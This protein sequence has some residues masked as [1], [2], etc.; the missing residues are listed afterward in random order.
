MGNI[1]A[2]GYYAEY[3][4]QQSNALC[5]KLAVHEATTRV[6]EDCSKDTLNNIREEL[7]S[8]LLGQQSPRIRAAVLQEMLYFLTQVVMSPETSLLDHHY[9][10]TVMSHELP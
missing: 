7:V 6:N 4:W 5:K 1:Y 8:I 9:F 10:L 2:F 3:I